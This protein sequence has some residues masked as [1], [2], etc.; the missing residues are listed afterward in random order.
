MYI[1]AFFFFFRR[2]LRIQDEAYSGCVPQSPFHIS[3][4]VDRLCHNT[5]T[6]RSALKNKTALSDSTRETGCYIKLLKHGNIFL[7]KLFF[8]K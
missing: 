5:S 3:V 6:E 2:M 4:H 1:L 8:K 7:S